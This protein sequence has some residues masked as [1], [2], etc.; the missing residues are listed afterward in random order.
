MIIVS[1]TIFSVSIYYWDWLSKDLEN[2]DAVR[3]IALSI[4]GVWA[5]YAVFL[6]AMRVKIMQQQ[7]VSEN[8]ARAAEQLSSDVMSI[9]ILAILSLGKIAEDSDMA[10]CRDVVKV[11]C[12]YIRE[13]RSAPEKHPLDPEM[14]PPDPIDMLLL[15]SDIQQMLDVLGKLRDKFTH[16]L[17]LL[18]LSR[19]DLVF[20]NLKGANL[21][22]ANLSGSLFIY[23]DLSDADLSN[24]NLSDANLYHANFKHANLSNANFGDAKWIEFAVNLKSAYNL[25]K[26]IDQKNLVS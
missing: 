6:A 16:S 25:P 9:R 22:G 7:Q 17:G 10:T 26:E 21:S 19:A 15:P 18:D 2:G 24:A 5:I 8:L 13:K 3:N 1:I 11:L 20:A 12:E 4:G 23:A 14:P